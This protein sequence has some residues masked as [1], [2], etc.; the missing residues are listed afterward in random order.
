MK[1]LVTGHRGYVGSRLIEVLKDGGHH[2]TG[3]DLGLFEGCEWE[4]PVQADESLVADV[5]ELTPHALE[6][7]DCVMHLAAIS[8]DPMGELQPEL[9]FA[10]NRDGSVVLARAAKEAGVPRFLFAGSCSVYGKSGTLPVDEA[11]VLAPRTAYARSKVEAEEQIK[12]L[13]DEDFAPVF[14]RSATA[15]GHSPMLRIDLV[16]NN[17]LASAHAF[18]SI[19]IMSDGTPWRPLIHCRDMA[20]AF[21]ALAEAPTERIRGLAIN[22]GSTDENY[23]V[24]EI[25]RQVASIVPNAMIEYAADAGPDDRSYQV[26]FSLLGRILPDFRFEYSLRSGIEELSRKFREHGFGAADF[27]GPRFVRLRTL[28]ARRELIGH[29]EAV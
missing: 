3:C 9:T 4:S 25:A 17:L 14:L 2:V 21:V 1:V 22:I 23:Q 12:L 19:R 24:R 20:R 18:G 16:A 15:Y 8:N 5:R 6:G 29:S 26:D 27:D 10:V 7:Y 28:Q 11:G 13:A